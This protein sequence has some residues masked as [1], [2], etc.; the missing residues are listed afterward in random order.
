VKSDANGHEFCTL[1]SL[2]QHAM[3]LECANVQF[4]APKFSFDVPAVKGH[5]EGTLSQ[6]H[7]SLDGTWRQ[8]GELPL[9]FRRQQTAIAL[10]PPPPVTFDPAMSPVPIDQIQAVL[11][12]DIA[13]AL[14]SGSLAPS[15]EGGVTI[16]VVEHGVRRVFSYGTARSDSIFEIGSITKTFTGLILAQLVEQHRVSLNDPVRTLLPP[17]TIAKPAGA[18]ITL[19]DIA[20]QHSGLP[21]LPANLEPKDPRN[22]YADYTAAD[23]YAF[24]AKQGVEKPANAPF[25]YSNL[26]FGLLGHA[27]AVHE[28]SSYAA[29]LKQEVT[30]PLGLRDTTIA[31]T[32]EQRARFV[33]GHGPNHR[34]A[35]AWD[36]GALE[37]AGAIRSTAGDMLTYLEA[38]LHPEKWTATT[39]S[40][41]GATLGGAL[42][43]QHEPRAD[44]FGGMKIGLAWLWDPKS[45]SYWHNGGTGGFSSYAF[46]IPEKDCAGIVLFNTT[47]GPNG[48]FADRLGEHLRQRLTGQ[49]AI[50]L[51]E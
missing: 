6:D 21:R 50:S 35:G 39:Q 10:A 42:K 26:G 19:L 43:L 36:L 44:A 4:T 46:F 29:L 49:P 32:A 48:S 2:D 11:D 47:L 12:K 37:G 16:G 8:G 3:G 15:T 27:L 30:D 51:S 25:L 7:S 20:T 23:L 24:L 22:P 18:E 34:A 41:E 1:D 13:G 38:N 33:Q 5:W 17:G 14:Q 45:G 9:H 28:R 40:P 31:L